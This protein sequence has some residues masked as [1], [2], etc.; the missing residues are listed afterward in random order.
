MNLLKKNC[1]NIGKFSSSKLY[2]F[3]GQG[4]QEKGMWNKLNYETCR[5]SL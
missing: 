1:K 4:T 3:A 2:V 5:A